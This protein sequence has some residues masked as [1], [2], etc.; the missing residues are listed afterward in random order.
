MKTNIT[1]FCVMKAGNILTPAFIRKDNGKFQYLPRADSLING[2]V[3]YLPTDFHSDWEPLYVE[4]NKSYGFKTIGDTR[5]VGL[6]FEPANLKD[7]VLFDIVKDYTQKIVVEVKSN[8]ENPTQYRIKGAKKKK[9]V[10]DK[11]V[12]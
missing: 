1:V 6:G 3:G 9:V 7:R 8:K 12:A 11:E 2:E 4:G 10:S 5:K